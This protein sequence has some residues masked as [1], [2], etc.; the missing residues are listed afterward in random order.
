MKQPVLNVR[1]SRSAA[2]AWLALLLLGGAGLTARTPARA[3]DPPVVQMKVSEY[4]VTE[5]AGFATLV[6]ER[7]GD[8]SVLSTV[9]FA[10]SDLTTNPHADADDDYVPIRNSVFFDRGETQKEFFITTRTD[11]LIEPDEP[12]KVTLSDP[13]GATLGARS[14]ATL[15]IVDAPLFTAPQ[16]INYSFRNTDLSLTWTDNCSNESN[17]EVWRKVGS[18]DWAK[19]ATRP[20][21]TTTFQDNGLRKGVQYSYRVRAINQFGESAFSPVVT[22]TIGGGGGGGGQG[23]IRFNKQRVSF[24]QVKVGKRKGGTFQIQNVGNAAVNLEVEQP[25]LPFYIY[26]NGG[27]FTLGK[28]KKRTI[29]VGFAPTAKG[30]FRDTAVVRF[31]DFE[32][33]GSINLLGKGK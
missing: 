4:R 31:V 17:Y 27:T 30:T 24:G 26:K 11:A 25:A 7:T 21:N 22:F 8:T 14:S 6:V 23:K 1:G 19:R 10:T 5:D 32:G 9:T 20:A 28:G 3:A 13:E 2:P 18:D 33:S 15:T 12:L 29:Y 16:N